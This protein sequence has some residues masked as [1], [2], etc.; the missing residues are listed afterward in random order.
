MFERYTE[1]ARRVIFFGKY[2]A[3]QFGSPY[4]E[5]EHLLLGL[6]RESKNLTNVVLKGRQ[7]AENIRSAIEKSTTIREKIATSV[8]LPLSNE[9]K[10]IIAYAAEEAERLGHKHIGTEHLLLG[11]LREEKCFAAQLLNE[12]RVTLSS[13]REVIMKISEESSAKESSAAKRTAGSEVALA[14]FGTDLTQQA[15]DNILPP[16]IGRERELERVIQVLCRLTCASPVLVGEPGVGKKSIVN[17]LAHRI[18]DSKVPASLA[19]SSLI[20]L[21]LAV[22]VSGT[23]SRLRF[24][25]NVENILGQLAAG[26]SFLFFVHGLHSFAHSQRFLSVV[27][28]LKPPLMHGG[29]LC[30]STATPAEYTKAI[31]AAPWLE[32]VFTVVEV[33]PPSQDEAL[34]TLRG[35]KPRFEQFHA[36]NYSDEALEYAVF[37]SINYFPNRYL[38]EKAVDLMDEAGA[39]VKLQVKLPDEVLEVQKRIKFIEHRR[40]NAIGNHELEKAR[41]YS[42]ELRKEQENLKA[43]KEK[44]KIADSA[45][46]IVTREHVEQVVSER[47]GISPD[48]LRKSSLPPKKPEPAK[49]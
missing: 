5:T 33:R 35:L 17:G 31:E 9:C 48:A 44:H 16:L 43:L 47:T 49:E 45:V 11:M 25:E 34:N 14:D 19:G 24:E 38:P 32:Q 6:L 13:A 7:A 41:F 42:D 1:K 27:N 26:D 21:D 46:M 3:S 22:T 2:E 15:M 4:I 29:I 20:S 37:H 18:V 28:V 12:Q 40:D 30:I 36:V 23:K 8:D 10:R 39:R